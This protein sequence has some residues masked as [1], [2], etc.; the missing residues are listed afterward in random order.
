MRIRKLYEIES[1]IRGQLPEQ[2]EALRQEK[3]LPII[4]DLYD[5]LSATLLTVSMLGQPFAMRPRAGRP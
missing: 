2:R 5:W 1:D 3:A 4:K